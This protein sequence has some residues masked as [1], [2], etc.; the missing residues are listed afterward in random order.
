VYE[1]TTVTT[2]LI[3]SVMALLAQGGGGGNMIL[4]TAVLVFII[5]FFFV[6]SRG[7]K[8]EQREREQMIQDLTRNQRVVTI[9]GMIGVVTDVKDDEVTIKIDEAN[10]TKVRMK[11]WSVRSVVP[12]GGDEDDDKK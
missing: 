11:K 5:V 8:R 9:G 7:R 6:S 3:D 10:N 1:E 4:W 12:K 2:D